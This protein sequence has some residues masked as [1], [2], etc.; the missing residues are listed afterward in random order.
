ML[1]LRS[2]VASNPLKT[3]YSTDFA[4]TNMKPSM[5]FGGLGLRA[6]V[7][8]LVKFQPWGCYVFE[9]LRLHEERAAKRS[10]RKTNCKIS[11]QCRS[12]S[13]DRASCATQGPD[14]LG[15]A[16]CMHTLLSC[17]L[18]SDLDNVSCGATSDFAIRAYKQILPRVLL[19][20]L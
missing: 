19:S 1:Q 11:S 18:L 4:V 7:N 2:A 12:S 13:N 3:L 14:R 16:L 17:S 6:Q 20:M 8:C 5:D 9:P 10:Q 15:S